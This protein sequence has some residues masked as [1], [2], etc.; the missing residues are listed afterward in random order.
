MRKEW[1]LPSKKQ[2]KVCKS[3][4]VSSGNTNVYKDMQKEVFQSEEP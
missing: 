4:Q 3:N 1:L 2:K